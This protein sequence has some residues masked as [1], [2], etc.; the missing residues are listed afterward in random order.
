V[1]RERD[2]IIKEARLKG[3]SMSVTDDDIADSGDR[4]Y[5]SNLSKD[6]GNAAY[7]KANSMCVPVSFT[8]LH[9][10]PRLTARYVMPPSVLQMCNRPQRERERERERMRERMKGIT[11]VRLL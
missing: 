2:E 5:E 10:C 9:D 3:A 4:R 1:W 7:A 8:C 6:A 11:F